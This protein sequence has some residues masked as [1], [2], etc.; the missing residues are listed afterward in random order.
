MADDDPRTA[1]LSENLHGVRADIADAL[2]SAGREDAVD[3]VVITKFHPFDDL[4]R[5]VELGVADIG[6][7]RVQEASGKH[8]RLVRER[9]D[10]AERVR[11]HMVGQ[12]QS[13][14]AGNVAAWADAVHSVDRERIADGLSRGRVR[15]LEAHDADSDLDVLL[16]LS[17]D[18]DT[19]RGGVAEEDLLPLAEHVVG[20]D[21]LR[22]GGV[23]VVPPLD[24]DPGEGF[25]RAAEI[26]A[27]LLAV[28]P[29]A[30][31]FSAGMT[32]D[33]REAVAAGSTCVRVGTAILGSRPIP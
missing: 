30:V 9:P 8:A 22:L 21:G 17:L 5:L 4:V 12:I 23:M 13:K 25:A 6:E 28:F 2:R 1:E 20:L 18:G 27:R 7:N 19:S 16:Q 24:V 29:D 26:R 32:A 3:L 15:A 33:L 14:K 31:T 10:L 11:W